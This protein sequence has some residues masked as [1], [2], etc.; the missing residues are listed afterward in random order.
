MNRK[1]SAVSAVY[2]FHQRRGVD[3]RD[4]LVAWRRRG[5]RGGSWRPLLAHL[6]SRPERARRIRMRTAN[7]CRP[8]WLNGRLL[9]AGG[10]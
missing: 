2:E 9:R 8:R 4:L 5:P 10:V 7:T 6:G 3:L 1:L